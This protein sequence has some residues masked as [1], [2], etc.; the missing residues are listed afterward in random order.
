[1]RKI[2]VSNERHVQSEGLGNTSTRNVLTELGIRNTAREL[3][4]AELSSTYEEA[5]QDAKRSGAPRCIIERH[6]LNEASQ[7]S[8]YRR[9]KERGVI[10]WSVMVWCFAVFLLA[11]WL[12]RGVL[13]RIATDFWI[14]SNTDTVSPADAVVVLGG[15][16]RTRVVG[17]AEY[18]GR[19]AVQK[20]LISNVRHGKSETLAWETATT[21][22]LLI[23]LGVPSAAIEL[24][25][26]ALSS[27]YEE[28][29][30]LR[31]WALRTHAHR[32]IVPTEAFSSRRVRWVLERELA[33]T[34]TQ[35][36]VPVLEHPAYSR[37]ELSK[38][39]FTAFQLEL[40]KYLYYRLRY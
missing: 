8:T 36:Q 4:G 9:M 5:I 22:S 32:L 15:G 16:L 21:R 13:F 37:S 1:M 12:S 2:L 27:T 23:E 35:V 10:G 26:A 18:Y 31:E 29:V 11:I 20:I 14:V 38:N 28:A 6:R 7:D 25:G 30:A 3:F 17:A 24:F 40:M 34:E 33:G 39:A 19:G